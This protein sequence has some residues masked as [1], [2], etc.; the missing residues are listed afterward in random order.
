MSQQPTVRL[1]EALPLPRT[2]AAT[3][4]PNSCAASTFIDW[5]GTCCQICKGELVSG[6]LP[7]MN[8]VRSVVALSIIATLTLAA[9]TAH[10]VTISSDGFWAHIASQRGKTT[11]TR[12]PAQQSQARTQVVC[13]TK[14][15][16]TKFRI[17]GKRT[18]LT[19]VCTPVTVAPVS[20]PGNAPAG[21]GPVIGSDAGTAGGS[22][23]D[24]S[25]IFSAPQLFLR[26]AGDSEHEEFEPLMTPTPPTS[27]VPEPGT[28]ALLGAGLAGLGLVRRRSQQ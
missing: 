23:S 6:D 2:Q 20:V 1:T 3:H 10:A 8:R 17:F 24:V 7:N 15:T 28:L 21:P 12:Q 22:H 16:V 27:E 19:R 9:T 13:T 14:Q 5:H 11:A 4:A 25:P 26:G 18:K